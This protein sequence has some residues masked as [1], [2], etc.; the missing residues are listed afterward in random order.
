MNQSDK[1]L[2]QRLPRTAAIA[3]ALA[4]G[5]ACFAAHAATNQTIGTGTIQY[6]EVI[7]GPA[8]LTMRTLTI[9]PGEVLGW[10]HHGGVGAY[11]IVVKG[12]LR[13]EDGCGGEVEYVEGQ[14]FLEAPNR[15]HRG[16]NLTGAT[17]V[18]AQTFIVPLGQPISVSHAQ[19]MCGAPQRV[20]ECQNDGW[21]AF[22]FPS[23]FISQ[24]QCEEVVGGSRR[25]F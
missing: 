14:A 13:L 18:T 3:V 15:V 19:R 8:T 10:H 2:T 7:G 17:V 20:E 9:A 11:T 12:L 21:R 6:S 1:R 25:A 4:A 5:F 24:E 16:K 23:S 22:N